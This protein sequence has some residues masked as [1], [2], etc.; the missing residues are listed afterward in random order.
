MKNNGLE[1]ELKFLL[2]EPINNFIKKF[3]DVLIPEKIYQKTVMYDNSNGLMQKSNGRIRLRQTGKEVTLSYKLPLSSETVKKEIEWE[4]KIDSWIIGDNIL[5]A[6]GFN[7]T[8]SYEK[9]RISF[10]Y[11]KVRIDIDEYPFSTFVEIE[12]NEK[13][14][15]KTALDIGFNLN[16]ALTKACD[17]LFSEWRKARGLPQKSH[18]LFKGYDK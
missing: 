15:K 1:I 2:K 14:I 12:G 5:K 11:K 3:P 6:M 16:K 17:N 18:M 10:N 4:T 7:K 9:Y 8:T 13:D